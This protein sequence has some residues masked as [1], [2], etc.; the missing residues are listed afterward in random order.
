MLFAG[1]DF[2]ALVAGL[3]AR[4]PSVG[5]NVNVQAEGGEQH[6]PTR[7]IEVLMKGCRAE[8]GSLGDL[9]S[10]YSV[11]DYN[12]DFLNSA[13]FALLSGGMQFN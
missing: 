3:S 11:D 2:K 7:H 1:S 12:I 13:D 6:Y 10:R 4:S 5:S 9:L 8:P